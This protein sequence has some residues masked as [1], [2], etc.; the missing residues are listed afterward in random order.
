MNRH[1]KN[2]RCGVSPFL[3]II[4][5]LII[6]SFTGVNRT[7]ISD[8]TVLDHGDGSRTVTW[9]FANPGNYSATNVTLSPG[10]ASLALGISTWNQTTQSDFETG[11]GSNVTVMSD[12]SVRLSSNST[13]LVKNGNF[14]SSADWTYENST[15]QYVM[16]Q[17][18][19][20]Q[21][22]ARLFD[23]ANS[24]EDSVVTQDFVS[25][26]GWQDAWDMSGHGSYSRDTTMSHDADGSSM[27]IS[28]TFDLDGSSDAYAILYPY[29]VPKDWS[30]TNRITYWFR[31]ETSYNFTVR[32]ILGWAS[33][34]VLVNSTFTNNS[35]G[36]FQV[37]NKREDF[38]AAA[39]SLS[40][41]IDWAAIGAIGFEIK[42]H[43]SG[44]DGTV[45]SPITADYHYDDLRR[46]YTSTARLDSMDN[47]SLTMWVES[48]SIASGEFYQNNAS[49]IAEGSGNMRVELNRTN[50]PAKYAV[51]T[52]GEEL[53]NWTYFRSLSFQAYSENPN[54]A[55]VTVRLEGNFGNPGSEWDTAPQNIAVGWNRYDFDITGFEG[56]GSAN[57][58]TL[59]AVD[60]V[61][62]LFG[63]TP[64]LTLVILYIDDMKLAPNELTVA[65]FNETAGIGQL[66]TKISNTRGVLGETIL[67]FSLAVE[68][69]CGPDEAELNV[70]LNGIKVWSRELTGPAPSAPISVD[71]SLQMAQAG[72]YQLMIQLRVKASFVLGEFVSIWID[73]VSLIASGEYISDGTLLSSVLDAGNVASWQMASWQ[74]EIP[75][76]STSLV[77]RT[78]SGQTPSVDPT[79]SAWSAD[80]TIAGGEPVQSPP[81]RY[82]QYAAILGTANTSYSP[83]LYEILIQYERFPEEGRIDTED[84][85][86]SEVMSWGR[87][88]SSHT[89]PVGTSIRYHYSVD[90]GLNWT[91]LNEGENLG[92]IPP[93]RVRFRAVL[94]TSN[95]LVAPALF[96][97]TLTYYAVDRL[98]HIHMSQ[99][100]WIG[101]ADD[102][103]D[104]GAFGHDINHDEVYFVQKWWTDNPAGSV[105]LF[106]LFTPGVTGV[107]RVYCNDSGGSISNYTTVNI[108]PGSVTRISIEPW[109][110][111]ILTTD[112]S[113]LFTAV[114]YDAKGNRYGP[115]PAIWSLAGAV[116]SIA[117]GPAAQSLFDP[118]TPGFGNVTADDGQGHTNSTN[119][120]QVTVGALGKIDVQP[121][122]I[123]LAVRE[124]ANFTAAGFDADD[125]PVQILTYLWETNA[126]MITSS[127]AQNATFKA[128]DL[129]IANGWIRIT[130]TSQG[131]IAGVA[132]VSVSDYSVK[133]KILGTIPD[134][135]KAEDYGSWSIDLSSY[136]SDPQDPISSLSW[137]FT[138]HDS[139]LTMIFGDGIPGSH[140]ITFT[141]VANAF[142]SDEVIIWLRDKDG[143]SD[144]QSIFINITSVNDRPF[145]QSITPFTIHYDVPYTYY[146]YDYVSDV[147]TS[148]ENLTLTSDDPSHITFNGLW[149]SFLYPV[150]DDGKTVYPMITVSDSDG[151]KMSTVLAITISNDYVPV[152]VRELPDVIMMEGQEIKNRFDLDDYFTDPDRDSLFYAHGNIHVTITINSNHSVDFKAPPNWNG[153]ETVSFRA[154]DPMNAR[155]EDIVMV[156]VLP[157]NSPPV[158]AGVPDLFVHYDDP[159]RPGYEYTFDLAGYVNDPDNETSDLIFDSSQP[160]HIIFDSVNKTQFSVHYAATEVGLTFPVTLFVSDGQFEADQTINITVLDDWP[161]EVTA[162]IPDVMFFEDTQLPNAFRISD[163]FTDIDG[164][165]L[166]FSSDSSSVLVTIDGGTHNVT[167]SAMSDWNGIEKVIFRATDSWGAFAE[168]TIDVTVLPVNDAP[169]ILSMPDIEVEVGQIAMIDLTQYIYD[170]DNDFAELFV[171]SRGNRPNCTSIAGHILVL[172]YSEVTVDTVQIEVSDGNKTTLASFKVSV[173]AAK[174]TPLWFQTYLPWLL[175]AIL[176]TLFLV[177]GLRRIVTDID[178][179][180]AFLVGRNGLLISHTVMKKGM[181][182]DEDLFSAMLS[183]IQDFVRHSFSMAD[184]SPIKKIDFGDRKIVIEGKK[185]M[186]IAAVYTGLENK[187]NTQCIRD[188]LDEIEKLYGDKILE[189]LVSSEDVAIADMI[190]EKHLGQGRRRR[191][192]KLRLRGRSRHPNR[193]GESHDPNPRHAELAIGQ[194]LGIGGKQDD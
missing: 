73:N 53:W 55:T 13:E 154:I 69:S 161:P 128:G 104:L 29:L 151:G 147:E 178:I 168:Q 143:Y 112:V 2:H 70:S 181:Q 165:I 145:I 12:G 108:L 82:L 25:I 117:P 3:L 118:T 31:S 44:D 41:E 42:E 74:E 20:S 190:L 54:G 98:D 169:M 138:D 57:Q 28:L 11:A 164:D 34:Y 75:D 184:S 162:D 72:Q 91:N 137:S 101:T 21:E 62:L 183:V 67:R 4:T 52:S 176:A 139:S 79:W 146:F 122:A 150:A 1:H 63:G 188:A 149:A 78:R 24:T 71:L 88:N 23:K 59:G 17:W 22:S 83:V 105:D 163:Y 33:D 173:V 136:A 47:I 157:V 45:A 64:P 81:S 187:R 174:T 130:A 50:N 48:E 119:T 114:G 8:P 133:P 46:W 140:V 123:S 26:V 9:D 107:F 87:F 36:W 111:G 16:A 32:T 10:N 180:E 30:L 95:T 43:P 97:M 115:V 153:V 172:R 191:Y 177:A 124:Y 92:P 6:S 185:Q 125:N 192:P 116:G 171:V 166:Q 159:G 120:F 194:D 77:I 175:A 132:N 155:A 127:T 193:G 148:K 113:L 61:R 142:G 186:F 93:Q 160:T 85:G 68:E 76:S 86:P 56:S 103:V 66:M 158:M 144:F 156:T 18:F 102:V 110:P 27:V 167:L 37:E 49:P 170:I 131:N 38:D 129:N 100:T 60:G 94:Q 135:V 15:L 40:L 109:D 189:L 182:V 14:T 65:M 35:I 179:E 121:R 90:S 126:G 106:G 5:L 96:N 51:G 7:A 99:A 39:S 58:N 84:F 134:Q 19:P 89:I 141:T 152:L 80:L